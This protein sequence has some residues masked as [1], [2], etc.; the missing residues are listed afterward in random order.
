MT[1]PLERFQL[2]FDGSGNGRWGA[3]LHARDGTTKTWAGRGGATNNEAEYLA[4]IRG[5][6]ETKKVYGTRIWVQVFG[7]S[8]LVIR[9]LTGEYKVRAQNLRT[10][11]ERAKALLAEFAQ[12]SIKWVP[13]ERNQAADEACAG[14][15]DQR[16]T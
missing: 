2:F 15:R 9:H 7:D 1:E 4:L 6:E 14:R 16:A 8:Q 10:Y 11:F 12:V 3:V 5:L 13:R